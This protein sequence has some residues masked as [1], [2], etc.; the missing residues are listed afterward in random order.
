M[1]R[2]LKELD[3]TFVKGNRHSLMK[4]TPDEKR[5]KILFSQ[6]KM[7]R[8]AE[9]KHVFYQKLYEKSIYNLRKSRIK[10]DLP[11]EEEQ[12]QIELENEIVQEN[13]SVHKSIVAST[14]I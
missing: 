13:K 9:K 11:E 1:K 6:T 4:M 2:E 12:Q 3:L 7:S 14:S 8:R 10:M 5:A